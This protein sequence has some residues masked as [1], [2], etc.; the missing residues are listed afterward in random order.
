MV[1]QLM[2]G[3]TEHPASVSG[4]GRTRRSLA[5]QA[6]CRAPT[7]LSI[8]ELPAS[9]ALA[10]GRQMLL[11][12]GC[13]DRR[14]GA[15]G[16]QPGLAHP[17]AHRPPPDRPAGRRRGRL[18]PGDLGHVIDVR[19]NDEIQDLAEAFNQM[20]ANLQS[21]RQELERWGRE[22]EASRRGAHP[23]AGREHRGDARAA[24]SSSGPA[25]RWPTPSPP[26]ATWTSCC[27]QVTQRHQRAVRL[28]PRRHLFVGCR[29]ENTRCCG[30]PTARADSRC[31]RAVT[32]SRWARRASSAASPA[33]ARPRIALD[34]GEDAVY[35]DNPDLPA[36]PLRDGPAP[37][38][39]RH[40]VIG[41]LDVQSTEPAA[42]D[43]EDVALLSTLADQVAIAI[44]NAQA[45]DE[46]QRAAGRGPKGPTPIRASESGRQ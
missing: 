15:G 25:A 18:A 4:P 41:A 36:H 39:R 27:R 8:V 5:Q 10:D 13:L 42:Y 3:E 31:W 11:L 30:R 28:V 37:D 24:P 23:G 43:E 9:E 6:P 19:T 1:R 35:F 29:A 34:V 2:A 32:G 7:G 46:T 20:A 12:A 21:S 44:A 38:R 16:R 40:Q 45:F 17:P 22:L 33:P 14:R 26:C